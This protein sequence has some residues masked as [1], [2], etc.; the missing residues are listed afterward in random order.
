M[1]NNYTKIS[2]GLTLTECELYEYLQ[3]AKGFCCERGWTW[4]NDTT[5][6]EKTGRQWMKLWAVTPPSCSGGV[7][8]FLLD[9]PAIES[10]PDLPIEGAVITV[11]SNGT[12]GGDLPITYS[13]QWYR[14]ATPVGTDSNTYTVVS[15][16][17]GFDITCVVTATNAYGD[18]EGTSNSLF[19]YQAPTNTVAPTTTGND[20]VGQV[21]S[22]TDGTWVGTSP[23]T[24][25][26]KWQRDGVDI[27]GATSSTYTTTSDDADKEIRRVVI[28]TNI[29][30]SVPANSNAVYIYTVEYTNVMNETIAGGGTLPTLLYR[31]LEN[32]ISVGLLAN[33]GFSA[34]KWFGTAASDGDDIHKKINWINP[35]GD[36]FV[37]DGSMLSIP[38]EG[39]NLDGVDDII[40]LPINLSSVSGITTTNISI[41]CYCPPKF[42][43]Q[44]F[45]GIGAF[46]LWGA[47]DGTRQTLF[48]NTG[49]TTADWIGRISS[50]TDRD[51]NNIKKAE[52][53]YSAEYNGTNAIIRI[54]SDAHSFA[55]ASGQTPP[56]Y[57]LGWGGRNKATPDQYTKGVISC[58]WVGTA[59]ASALIK[60]VL[61]SVT[62]SIFPAQPSFTLQADWDMNVNAKMWQ[63]V[64]KT[65]PVS[66]GDA[67]RVIEANSGT[68][69]LVAT[70]D[71]NRATFSTVAINTLGAI[72][73]AGDGDSYALPSTITGDHLFIWVFRNLDNTNGSHL[74]YGQN[75]V[76]VTGTGYVGN[77]ALGGAYFT[78]HPSG[79]AAGGVRLKNTSGGWN[80]ISMKARQISGNTYEWTCVNGLLQANKETKT[81]SFQWIEIGR[82]Y[83]ANWEMHG[84][85]SRFMHYS[86]IG[87]DKDLQDLII[88]LNS[89]YAL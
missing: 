19:V 71:S 81:A 46:M 16:D 41:G 33:G 25:T 28:G 44:V 5:N 78:P 56:N 6:V 54:G 29:I 38:Y 1:A 30:D 49:G 74:V 12:W 76:P 65:I 59:N 79:T 51:T 8:P 2:T 13:Y 84:P 75:Y 61:D 55:Q 35:S 88:S 70:S 64:A 87:T 72:N 60:S 22:G 39:F 86:G 20:Y 47:N 80:V 9:S 82:Q 31:K 68:G 40:K 42:I 36:K 73:F 67:V 69:D 23:V 62:P 10:S 14:D 83:L 58:W 43:N 21:L 85:L 45:S 15:A 17:I 3:T 27:V 50:S 7:A 24:L 34:A 26:Y 4:K 53:F 48:Y 37:L 11:T 63:D 52:Q 77:P 66:N 32:R 89:T 18:D 57:P